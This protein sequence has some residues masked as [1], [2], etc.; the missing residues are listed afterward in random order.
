MAVIEWREGIYCVVIA[1]CKVGYQP[2]GEICCDRFARPV[3]Y[4]YLH[5]G[6]LHRH[7]THIFRPTA[8]IER[9]Y[10]AIVGGCRQIVLNRSAGYDTAIFD[11]DGLFATGIQQ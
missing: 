7:L 11:G 1:E 8:K 4:M 6:I 2:V 10:I 5:A 9:A 3:P